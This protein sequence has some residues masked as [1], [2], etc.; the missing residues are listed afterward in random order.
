MKNI[1]NLI[2]YIA[3]IFLLIQLCNNLQKSSEKKFIKDNETFSKE[4]VVVKGFPT[5]HFDYDTVPT[6][7]ETKESIEDRYQKELISGAFV[8]PQYTNNKFSDQKAIYNNDIYAK[9][10]HINRTMDSMD[11]NDLPKTI[12]QIFDESITD[13]KKLTP[14]KEYQTGNFIIQGASNLSTFN[15][16]EFIYDDEK[17]ENGGIFGKDDKYIGNLNIYPYD[18][19]ISLDNALF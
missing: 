12:A 15:P 7:E 8:N 11:E 10:I 3:I 4:L 6:E 19:M 5:I 17:P 13:F 18:N 2:I 14:P 16:D 1:F 9:P